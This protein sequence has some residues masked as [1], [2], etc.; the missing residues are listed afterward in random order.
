MKVDISQMFNVKYDWRTKL[1]FNWLLPIQTIALLYGFI[2]YLNDSKIELTDLDKGNGYIVRT[3]YFLREAN[4][5][6]NAPMDTLLTITIDNGQK[7]TLN[8]DLRKKF[9]NLIVSKVNPRYSEYFYRVNKRQKINFYQLT[10]DGEMIKEIT[11]SNNDSISMS[12][13]MGFLCFASI[14]ALIIRKYSVKS[15]EN[16]YRKKIDNWIDKIFD[17]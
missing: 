6:S 5:S 10:I 13:L 15:S 9:D 3:H 12:V 17:D 4:S 8:N 16:K 14:V 11:E 1:Y 7:L 2:W